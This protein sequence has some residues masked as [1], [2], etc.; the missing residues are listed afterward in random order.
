M[1]QEEELN[2]RN[3]RFFH[4]EVNEHTLRAEEVLLVVDGAKAA[5]DPAR[6]VVMAAAI[7]ILIF[8]GL[9]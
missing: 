6:R 7:F 1:E 2:S 9:G 5:A 3:H 8:V 4:R